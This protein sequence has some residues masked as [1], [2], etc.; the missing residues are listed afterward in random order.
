MKTSLDPPECGQMVPFSFLPISLIFQSP[1]IKQSYIHQIQIQITWYI[2]VLLIRK[3][4]SKLFKPN[5]VHFTFRLQPI[6]LHRDC[7]GKKYSTTNCL[8]QISQFTVPVGSGKSHKIALWFYLL[9][10]QI[11]VLYLLC[12]Q[13][14][15]L[16]L[17]DVS[18][19]MPTSD[20][21]FLCIS[22]W[23]QLSHHFCMSFL[24]L[25]SPQLPF[26]NVCTSLKF[27]LSPQC[28]LFQQMS[29][30]SVL[31]I[32]WNTCGMSYL[33]LQNPHFNFDCTSQGMLV[34]S[35]LPDLPLPLLFSLSL[36]LL[37][38]FSP[39]QPSK[40]CLLPISTT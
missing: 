9:A 8:A 31:L 12:R 34:L 13:S 1:R 18:D 11:L 27:C 16:G 25:E 30:A 21:W 28:T 39:K 5:Y 37:L 17:W 20:L 22:I 35:W 6:V 32:R 3:N 10:Q 7:H 36:M 23:F 40:W 15:L 26:K 33:Y 38:I 19:E 4:P 24:L 14:I 2:Q 29:Q